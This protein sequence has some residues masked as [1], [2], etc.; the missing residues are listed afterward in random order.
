MGIHADPLLRI[1]RI[2]NLLRDSDLAF[3]GQGC[4]H[5]GILGIT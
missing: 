3:A 1:Q 5:D 2:A 4:R